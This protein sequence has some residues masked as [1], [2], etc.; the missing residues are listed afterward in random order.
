MTTP[1]S[2]PSADISGAALSLAKA[3]SG[4]TS[5]GDN[6]TPDSAEYNNNSLQHNVELEDEQASPPEQAADGEPE[7]DNYMPLFEYEVSLS[8]DEFIEPD[9]PVEQERF[10]RR[11]RCQN[12][13][14][15]SRGSRTVRLGR[16]VTGGKGHEVLPRFGPSRWR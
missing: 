11:C 9:D 12:R 14:I 10:K 15:S 6:N 2:N 7:E 3:K 13:R 8:D 1:R 5:T 16:M 4:D